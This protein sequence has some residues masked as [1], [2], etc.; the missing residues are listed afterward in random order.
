ML[1]CQREQEVQQRHIEQRHLL[2]AYRKAVAVGLPQVA[3]VAPGQPEEV[4]HMPA[5][6]NEPERICIF[7]KSCVPP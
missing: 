1:L 7:I 3:A 6:K 4:A 2:Q 5:K